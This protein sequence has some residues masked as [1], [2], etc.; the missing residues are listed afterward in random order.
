MRG[1]DVAAVVEVGIEI[2]NRAGDAQDAVH[3][4]GRQLQALDRGFQ[5]ELILRFESAIACQF[6]WLQAAVDGAGTA[7][8]AIP[9]GGDAFAHVAAA[10]TARCIGTQFGGREALH[11]DM[12]IDAV[13]DRP[14]NAAAIALDHLHIAIAATADV[15]C[16]ATRARIHRGDQLEARGIFRS[17]CRTR[18]VHRSGLQ[19]FAQH[20]QRVP[21]PLG[22]E[23]S[24]DPLGEGFPLLVR[25]GLVGPALLTG[26]TAIAL[27]VSM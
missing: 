18:D 23:D 12:E 3:R 9:R 22:L 19:R 4:A 15:A 13:E 14:G 20:F 6:A 24:K 26:N 27:L 16:P 2:G 10:F 1:G 7:E 5:Q 25:H 11:V 17:P 8:L 21:A